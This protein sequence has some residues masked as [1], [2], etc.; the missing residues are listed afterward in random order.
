MVK[1][2]LALVLLIAVLF[3][4]GKVI[5]NKSSNSSNQGLKTNLSLETPNINNS[6]LAKFYLW[7][8]EDPLFT[9]PDFDPKAFSEAVQTLELEEKAYLK[10]TKKTQPLFPED[11]LKDLVVVSN[12]HKNFISNP[13]VAS[14]K[15]LLNSY[16]KAQSNYKN[17]QETFAAN[18]KA[19][20][21]IRQNATYLGVKIS[22]NLSIL[23]DDFKKLGE[24]AQA[25]KKEIEAR[26]VCLVKGEGCKRP[27]YFFAEPTSKVLGVPIFTKKDILPF[28]MLK[29][30]S[31][32]NISF[33]GP[34]IA[35][36]SCFGSGPGQ[37][38]SYLFYLLRGKEKRSFLES[39]K[40]LTV[41][42]EKIATTNYYRKLI[43]TSDDTIDNSL[44]KRGY[45]W[46]IHYETHIYTCADSSY[47][48]TIASLDSLYQKN[49]DNLIFEKILSVGDLD[50]EPKDILIRG[51]EA[52]NNF[53]KA[54]FPSEADAGNLAQE[55]AYVYKNI[56]VWANDPK[57][58][59]K[60][61]LKKAFGLRF[62]IL[63]RYLNYERKLSNIQEI[64]AE[65]A[66][67]LAALRIKSLINNLDTSAYA[68]S[69]R[70]MYGL[71]YFP[72]SPSFFRIQDK[73]TYIDITGDRNLDYAFLTFQEAISKY[74]LDEVKKWSMD[75]TPIL[76]E[77]YAKFRQNLKSTSASDK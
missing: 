60:E 64:I 47:K 54:E 68:Y 35:S 39:G 5:V 28:D 10:Q 63:D 41:Q 50:K 52:E 20:K 56:V 24:N 70:N 25:L 76:E 2:I 18:L 38:P 32:D 1:K 12:N 66:G 26:E 7:T 62:E 75:L 19:N 27:A 29:L 11:F 3:V 33:V 36:T 14:A 55:Y 61:W 74:P 45:D 69:F 67:H 71:T 17:E 16:K 44:I 21:D 31:I 58:K 8:R 4:L 9:S 42:T 6:N 77:D 40:K 65:A 51:K 59:N 73:L 43:K 46:I 49:K 13:T 72:F 37:S 15:T 23:F 30:S 22:T 57:Y 53:F 34:Y 48:N